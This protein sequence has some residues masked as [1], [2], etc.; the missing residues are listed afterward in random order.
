MITI[1]NRAAVLASMAFGVYLDTA[2]RK[3]TSMKPQPSASS[4]LPSAVAMANYWCDYLMR[5]FDND[6]DSD[7]TA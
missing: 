2:S 1:R 5:W 3:L 4:Y 6:H 7:R